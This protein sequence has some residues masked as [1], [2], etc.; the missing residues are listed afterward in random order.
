MLTGLPIAFSLFFISLIGTSFF[1][2][3]A[4]LKQLTLN[5]YTSLSSFVLMPLPL[6]VLM[7]EVMFQSGL[8]PKMLDALDM[9]IGRLPGRLGLLAVGGGALFS[10]LTGDTMSSVAMLG[11]SLVPEMEKRG[12]K[13]PMNL[14]PILGSGGLAILIP[15]SS[16]AVF[17]ATI[18]EASVGKMIIAIIVP[19]ILMA[20]SYAVYIIL[21]C[22][23]QPSIAPPYKVPTITLSEKLV[24][25]VQFILP[26]GFIVFLV[27]G[28]I[29]LGIATPSEAA[30]TGTIGMFL[31]VT[32]YKR[33]TWGLVKKSI[34]ETVKISGM[35][36]LILASATIYSQT[37][38][39]SGATRGLIEYVMSLSLKP[40][41]IIVGMIIIL[42]FLG[43]FLSPAATIVITV[44]LFMPIINTLGVDKV[45]V[46]VLVLITA[47]IATISPP[48][49][50][51]LFIMKSVAPPNTNMED[52]FRAAL[53]FIL[54]SL[55]VLA[56]VIA[57]PT[58]A[59]WLPGIMR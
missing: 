15:P 50:S 47:Q 12:Y 32:A 16:L 24:N 52:I 7:G 40:T 10:T 41:L 28:I 30:A 38:A 1:F 9:W 37:L 13:Q 19:G 42:I 59:L 18:A 25:T 45:W 33:M 49:G 4:G 48:F 34:I 51:S 57:F 8:A 31:L 11:G 27:V 56:L 5:I 26:I 43:M 54:C 21:K 29:L 53:P 17:V 22:K 3:E 39:A 6:F 2:G 20:F 55:I 58:I 36:F 46:A 35:I 14:G 44:P 23:F